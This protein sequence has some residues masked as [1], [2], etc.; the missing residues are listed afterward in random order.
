MSRIH[1][2][3]THF[4]GLPVADL[5]PPGSTETSA[6]PGEPAH[7]GYAEEGKENQY[8]IAP[9][10]YPAEAVA[11]RLRYRHWEDDPELE[12]LYDYFLESVD[13]TKVTALVIGAWTEDMSDP[14]PLHAR[15]AADADRFPALRHLFLG[16][17]VSEE[18]EISWID[19]GALTPLLAAF[20]L[21]E[22]L[23]ARGGTEPEPNEGE[24]EG[25]E[26]EDGDTARALVPFRHEHLRSL[27]FESGGLPAHIVRAVGRSDLPALERLDIMMGVDEYGGD[28]TVDDLTEILAGTR[29]PSLRHLGL[30]NSEQQDE[31]AAA[32]AGAAVTARLESLDL[33]MGT[34]SDEGAEALLAGQPLGHLKTLKVDHHFLSE[35]MADRIK[36]ALQ[37]AGVDVVLSDPEVRRDWGGDGRYVAVAE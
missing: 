1:D 30:L 31:I 11:W 12:E 24:G 18:S 23:S 34:L 29:L 9:G 37:P 7:D 22:E 35:P 36:A 27:A 33:S 26:D 2:H 28:T 4:G 15:L 32:V 19:M 10:E 8:G 6:V 14:N 17:I 16:D 25:G 5:R 13:T 21:L 20:P 3:L